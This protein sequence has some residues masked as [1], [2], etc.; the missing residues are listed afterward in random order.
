M[1]FLSTHAEQFA[2]A[3]FDA[4][5]DRLNERLILSS[6]TPLA[7]TSET[8]TPDQPVWRTQT[9]T[10]VPQP[11]DDTT[12]ATPPGDTAPQSPVQTPAQAS[13]GAVGSTQDQTQPMLL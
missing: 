5:V 10:L 9:G 4:T 8:E 3:V 12:T 6:L 13:E 2:R 7:P 11:D 1:D